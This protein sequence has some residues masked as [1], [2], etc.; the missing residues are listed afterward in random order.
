MANRSPMRMLTIL[1]TETDSDILEF[2]HPYTVFDIHCDDSGDINPL[3]MM[4]A[5]VATNPGETVQDLYEINEPGAQWLGGPVSPNG[6]HF[7]LE[8]AIGVRYLQLVLDQVVT[9][10]VTMTVTAMD[11]AISR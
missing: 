1:D 8:M 6:F 5:R 4:S 2:K 3:A 7:V 11:K 10:D 9:D